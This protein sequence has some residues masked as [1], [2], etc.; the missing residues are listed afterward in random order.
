MSTCLYLDTARL[1]QMCPEAQR[2]DRDFARLAGEEA[3]SLYYDL[4][5]RAG[6]FSLSPSLRHR[7]P[8]LSDWSGVPSLKNRFKIALGL[9]R[10]R[11]LLLANRSAVLVRLACRALCRRCENVLVTDMLWPAYRAVLDDECRRQ[12]RTVTT[13]CLERAILRDGIGQA[14]LIDSVLEAYLHENC[15]GLFLSAVTC[16]GVHMP[17]A[18]LVT[19][20]SQFRRPEFV[21]V[22]AAQAV[23]HVPLERIAPYCDFLVAG[24]HKWL[25]AYHPMG[26]GFCGRPEAD[27]VFAE[28]SREMAE[29]GQLDDPLLR[30]TWELENDRCDSF[31]ETVNLAPLFTTAAAVSRLWH[32]RHGRLEEFQR[33]VANADRFAEIADA[34]AWRPVR[35]DGSMRSGILLLQAKAKQ[36]RTALPDTVRERFRRQGI[37]VSAYEGGL[38]RT[39]LLADAIPPKHLDDVRSALQS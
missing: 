22:D 39:S 32:S 6:F 38:I 13:V 10:A 3:G 18:E 28:I 16:R 14:E 15:D 23:N 4:F 33:Q 7:Y 1:G 36:A 2:A 24:C 11:P 25:R 17:V 21:L 31:S 9:P 29:Q 19:S 27:R 37:A 12:R 30:F 8:G 5:L 20:V 34:S 26:L 35:P